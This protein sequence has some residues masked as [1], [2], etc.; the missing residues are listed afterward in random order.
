L[1]CEPCDECG[2]CI[3]NE[4]LCDCDPACD[5]DLCDCPDEVCECELCAVCGGCI[6]DECCDC[7][8]CE[9]CT[10]E[11]VGKGPGTIRAVLDEDETVDNTD[12]TLTVTGEVSYIANVFPTFIIELYEDAFDGD[13][14]LGQFTYLKFTD[15]VKMLLDAGADDEE[16]I[17]IVVEWTPPLIVGGSSMMIPFYV[18]ENDPDPFGILLVDGQSNVEI[19]VYLTE[20]AALTRDDNEKVLILTLNSNITVGDELYTLEVIEGQGGTVTGS[21]SG[22][23]KEGADISVTAVKSDGYTFVDWDIDGVTLPSKTV[24]TLTFKMP[25]NNVTLT[26][27]FAPTGGGSTG[28]GGGGGSSGATLSPNKAD[29]DK[30]DAKDITITLTPNGQTLKAIKNGAYTLKEG[31]DYTKNGN[32][33]VIKASYLETLSTGTQKLVFEMSGGTNPTFTITVKDSSEEKET[34]P[35]YKPMAPLHPAGTKVEATKTNNILILN[36]KETEFPAVKIGGY[37]WIKLRDFAMLLNGTAK[38]F[39]VSYDETTRIVDIRTGSSYSPLGDELTDK[40]SPTENATA[41]TQ[42]LRVNGTFVD[43]AAYNIKGYNYLRV[44]DLAI[45]LNFAVK[46][47]DDNSQ[48]TLDLENPYDGE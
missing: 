14:P 32:T 39:S 17:Y 3:C 18:D 36:E 11:E 12:I 33:V 9:P 28:S 15:F 24:E 13:K 5:C 1:G 42:R 35:G 40:L 23:Y 46:Y 16:T 19:K 45:I 4:A 25:N 2:K 43:V 10:C 7:E 37:N 26:A 8:D 6:E 38:N 47:D 29:F 31:T 20:A 22:E 41:T 30:N 44:R 21:A 48:I 34:E 27:N